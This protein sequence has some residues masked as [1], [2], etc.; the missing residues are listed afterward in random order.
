MFLREY[1]AKLIW[2]PLGEGYRSQPGLLPCCA[3][4]HHYDEQT[5]D[6]VMGKKE[7]PSGT[8]TVKEADREIPWRWG[9]GCCE[10]ACTATW[11][12][13]NVWIPAAAKALCWCHAQGCLTGTWP[14]CIRGFVC[15]LCCC[16]R[17]CRSLWSEF[18]LTVKSRETTYVEHRCRLL[19]MHRW[20]RGH[21]RL[22]WQ[23]LQPNSQN[24]VAA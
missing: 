10:V 4:R 13:G 11:G 20:Q 21:G 18:P 2:R 14:Y 15:G 9:P 17:P 16:Q 3:G 12:R 7:K 19:Q 5:H 1:K 6:G 24:R 23:P 22:L 8:C